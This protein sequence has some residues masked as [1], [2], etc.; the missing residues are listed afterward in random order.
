MFKLSNATD[1]PIKQAITLIAL[2][3]QTE[4]L[5]IDHIDIC[6]KLPSILSKIEALKEILVA[7]GNNTSQTIEYI[8]NE[9]EYISFKTLSNKILGISATGKII[10]SNPNNIHNQINEIINKLNK[11]SQIKKDINQLLEQNQIQNKNFQLNPQQY[12]TN[13]FF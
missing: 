10:R 13:T 11:N 6:S 5:Q 8:L 7:K 1:D 9:I 2:I 4:V 3:N 12:P